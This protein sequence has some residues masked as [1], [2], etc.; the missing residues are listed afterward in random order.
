MTLGRIFSI[1]VLDLVSGTM[2]GHKR[3]QIAARLLDA[4]PNADEWDLQVVVKDAERFVF[5]ARDIDDDE[6]DIRLLQRNVKRAQNDLAI[7]YDAAKKDGEVCSAASTYHH[8]SREYPNPSKFMG[9]KAKTMTLYYLLNLYPG[10]RRSR[11]LRLRR[12]R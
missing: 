10:L 3:M 7:W 11:L 6:S 2:T 8:F 4:V 12:S 1:A 5:L 9:H